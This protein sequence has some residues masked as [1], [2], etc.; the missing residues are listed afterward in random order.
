MEIISLYGTEI[1]KKT[2]ELK[3]QKETNFICVFL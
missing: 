3:G 2:L 1:V